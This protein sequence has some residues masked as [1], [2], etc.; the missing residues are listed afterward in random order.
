MVE[1]I[2][3]WFLNLGKE[4]N[5]NLYIFGSIYIGAIPFFILCLSWTIR[6]IR[7]K[8]GFVLPLMLTSFF[9]ISAYLY[10]IVVGRNIPVWV[11]IFISLAIAYGVYSSVQKIKKK[12]KHETK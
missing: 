8:K 1:A 2:K 11:Y 5:V 6:N 10:L 3:E 7:K 12:L 9:F 4:Y